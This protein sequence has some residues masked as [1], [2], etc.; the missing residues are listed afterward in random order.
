MLPIIYFAISLAVSYILFRAVE[1]N[2]AFSEPHAFEDVANFIVFI[3]YLI[4]W[5]VLVIVAW[6]KHMRSHTRFLQLK[7]VIDL[8]TWELLIRSSRTT[9][10]AEDVRNH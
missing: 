3:I 10:N 7:V 6:V 9:R 5:P 2:N 1:R 8:T 4:F